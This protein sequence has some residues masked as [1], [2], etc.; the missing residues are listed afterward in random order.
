MLQQKLNQGDDTP[1]ATEVAILATPQRELPASAKP[2]PSKAVGGDFGDDMDSDEEWIGK[3]H[4]LNQ[5]ALS[6]ARTVDYSPKYFS[7]IDQKG[8]RSE[9]FHQKR[10]NLK[11]IKFL[12]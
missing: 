9:D 7:T 2:R 10:K 3:Q 1:K 8:I 4:E 5:T 12:I 11:N 6:R